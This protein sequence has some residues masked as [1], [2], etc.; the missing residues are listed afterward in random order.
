M[1]DWEIF[2]VVQAR[3]GSGVRLHRILAFPVTRDNQEALHDMFT[4]QA[5]SLIQGRQVRVAAISTVNE[6]LERK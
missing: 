2:N 3:G 5:S 1:Y 4:I 6:Q